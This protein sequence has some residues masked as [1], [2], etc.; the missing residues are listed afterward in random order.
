MFGASCRRTCARLAPAARAAGRRALCTATARNVGIIAHIDAGKTTTTERMLLL[1]GVS[2]AAGQVDAGDTVMDF[3]EQERTRGI[4][5][6]A[7]ATTFGWAGHEISLIDTPG[8]V[9]FMVEV[10]RTVRVLDGAALVVDAVA[11]VQA[12]TGTVWAQAREHAVP[13]VAFV[14][15]MDRD[16]ADL[17]GAADSLAERL[18]VTPLLVQMPLTD[19]GGTFAG[20]VDLLELVSMRWAEPESAAGKRV[21]RG[22][23]RE[24]LTQP[25]LG[26]A[27]GEKIAESADVVER[28]LAARA[29]LV[30]AVA[31]LEPDGEVAECFL[32]EENVPPA[33]LR[34]ALRRLAASGAAVP[35]LCGA[36]LHG[37]GVEPL[38]DAIVAYLP[39]PHERPP[40]T[41]RHADAAAPAA[42]AGKPL[43]DAAEAVALA[44]KVVHEPRSRKPLVWLRVYHGAVRAAEPLH[45]SRLGEPE[46]PTRLV[47]IH[48]PHTVDVDAAGEGSIVAALGLKNTRTGD[49]LM[50]R[51]AAHAENA[52]LQG[53]RVPPPV[54]FCA[55][56]VHDLG[57]ISA[58]SR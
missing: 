41:L 31:E 4:T 34:A 55:L 51:P 8:H 28:A 48:G 38:L 39:A 11:G 23:A 21:A 17:R 58:T 14:N 19:G 56:E 50:L 25:L 42:P 37:V 53:V 22:A 35:T 43:A 5:I 26:S 52:R 57:T 27:L 24:L 7:A 16:G 44:F 36:S 32:A 3:M 45:N 54:F 33:Q 47:R 20:V 18:R 29:E 12:Q 1:A 13:A 15:K 46:R 9:D 6:Q 2:R 30:E 49:T 40:A 10:E